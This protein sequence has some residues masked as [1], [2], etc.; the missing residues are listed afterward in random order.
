MTVCL[1]G[2]MLYRKTIL[3]LSSLI[4]LMSAGCTTRTRSEGR[5]SVLANVRW[6]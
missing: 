5:S 1:G 4:L 3:F 2:I 6:T